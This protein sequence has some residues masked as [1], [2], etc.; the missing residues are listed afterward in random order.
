MNSLTVTGNI[1]NSTASATTTERDN[2]VI[3]VGDFTVT[4]NIGNYADIGTEMQQAHTIDIS[5]ELRNYRQIIAGTLTAGSICNDGIYSDIE[6]EGTPGCII[7]GKIV[8]G[9]FNN[10]AGEISTGLAKEDGKGIDASGK[11]NNGKADAVYAATIQAGENGWIQATNALNNIGAASFIH[12]GCITVVADEEEGNLSNDGMIQA[13]S[14]IADGSVTNSATGIIDIFGS[15]QIASAISAVSIRNDGTINLAA[16]DM[17]LTGEVINNNRINIGGTVTSTGAITNTDTITIDGTLIIG[18]TL[19]IAD[20]AA[21]SASEGSMIGFD[22]S[23][24]APGA[25]ARVNDLALVQGAP[26]YAVTVST[27]QT[28]GTYQLAGGAA[29]FDKTVTVNTSAGTTLGT[30]SI[31]DALIAGGYKYTLANEGTLLTL[32]VERNVEIAVTAAGNFY[33]V[34]GVFQ[35]MSDGRGVVRTV[36]AVTNL[37]GSVDLSEWAFSAAGDFA[38]FGKDGLLWIE[39]ATGYAYMQY[40]MTSFAEVNAKA[41]CLGVL[42]EGYT[43]KASGDFSASGIDGVLMQGPTFGDPEVSLNYGL[44]AWARDNTGATYNGW[45][46]ALINTWEPGDP[47]KGDLSD[48]AS[49]NANNYSYDIVGVGDFNGDGRDDVMIRNSMP[50]VVR[51][52][53][54]DYAITGSGDIF[55]FLTGNDIS[56]YQE[57]NTVYAACAAGGWSVV[58]FGDFDNDG[59][60]DA[61]LTDGTGVA[62]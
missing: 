4:G 49:I 31:G 38:G 7:A 16:S 25:E 42:G 27:I 37:D 5:G 9:E 30:V 18:G 61:L 58:G 39:K 15:D 13:Q 51:Q 48:P 57:I 46:G 32:E 53:E 60:D 47:L 11:I 14:I 59:I 28:E 45:L 52:D 2:S 43:V 55:T 17:T 44:P 1:E 24:V 19:F 56:G 35:L 21:V 29:D 23:A 33:G 41:N 6:D 26:D 54:I 8:T 50:E 40:D 22:I 3:R 34:G 36:E 20:G 12:A 62:G 10:F